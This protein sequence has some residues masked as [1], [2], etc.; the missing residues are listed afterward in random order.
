VA[1]L[2]DFIPSPLARRSDPASSHLAAA[3]VELSG[4]VN[5]H[6]AIILAGVKQQPGSTADELALVTGLDRVAIGKRLREMVRKGMLSEGPMRAC[7]VKGRMMLTWHPVQSEE[8][9]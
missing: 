4:T 5:R 2:F 7:R 3:E 6:E 1:D 8:S 9:D